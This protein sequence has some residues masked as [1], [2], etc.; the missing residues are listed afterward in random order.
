MAARQDRVPETQEPRAGYA[1]LDAHAGVRL[2][3]DRAHPLIFRV[4]N[5]LDTVT[6]TISPGWTSGASPCPGAT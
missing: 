1:L 6:A 5:A 3:E 2:G 4:D